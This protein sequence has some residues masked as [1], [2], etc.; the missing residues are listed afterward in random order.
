[1]NTPQETD[2]TPPSPAMYT[3]AVVVDELIRCGVREAVVCPGSRSAPLALAFTEAARTYRLRLHVRTDERTG[4]FLAL[5]LA[6]YSRRPVPIV[7]TS[8]SA[9]AQCLPAMVEASL[10]H[11]PLLV[12]SANRPWSY[13]GS[14]ANQTIDQR[15]IFG[16]HAVAAEG[17]DAATAARGENLDAAQRHARAVVDRLLGAATDPARGGGAHLDIPLDDGLVPHSTTEMS[18][19]AR[20]VAEQG[21]AAQP[22]RSYRAPAREPYGELQVDISAP[23]LVVAGAVSQRPWARAVLEALAPLP[24][25]AEPMSPSPEFPVHSGAAHLF[26]KTVNRGDL[27]LRPEQIIVVGRPT[28]HRSVSTLLADPSIRV[29]VLTD[30]T[31]IP[32]VAH[33]VRE[34]GSSVCLV[35]TSPQQWIRACRAISDIG[36]EAVRESLAEGGEWPDFTGVHAMAAVADS[37]R[38]GDACVIG[39]S[40]T[41][42]DASRAG[43][44]FAGVETFSSRGAAGID[45]TVST[46]IGVALCHEAG[47]PDAV[48]APRTVAVMGDLTFIHDATGLS[49]GPL[50]PAPENLLLVVINDDGGAI[51]EGLEPGAEDL[52][53]FADGTAAFERVFGTPTGYRIAGAC[54]AAGVAYHR[55]ETLAELEDLLHRHNEGELYDPEQRHPG[56]VLVEACVD[57]H[58]RRALEQAI[59]ARGGKS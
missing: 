44:P 16:A 18:M 58:G 35:G 12:L 34:V 49:I 4:S 37:L 3:A 8:G 32:D 25:L 33:T 56:M 2:Q 24:V 20:R 21:N 42:R 52:R 55:A 41:I 5:G 30:T 31:T 11:I 59:A 29:V 22:Q 57:R 47:H 39:A 28:L 9:V 26:T 14:G 38:D 7:M 15:D 40:S 46:A 6:Q 43:L 17:L 10:S 23:T 48:R 51:F 50:E 27:D 54:A 1:M 13:L 19:L 36:V 53:A 45:G